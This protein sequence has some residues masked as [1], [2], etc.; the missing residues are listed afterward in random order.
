MNFHHK[1]EI[2]NFL[3][4]NLVDVWEYLKKEDEGYTFDPKLN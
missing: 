3:N 2:N 4:L 1:F